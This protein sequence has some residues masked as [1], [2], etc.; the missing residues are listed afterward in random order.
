[1]DLAAGPAATS[2]PVAATPE[3]SSANHHMS[4]HLDEADDRDVLRSSSRHLD[5]GDVISLNAETDLGETE[6]GLEMGKSRNFTLSPE[7]TDYD[8]SELDIN[9]GTELSVSDIPGMNGGAEASGPRQMESFDAVAGSAETAGRR[10]SSSKSQNGLKG[11]FSSMPILED[12]LSSGQ[13]SVGSSASVTSASDTEEDAVT[14]RI[15]LMADRRMKQQPLSGLQQQQQHP[16]HPSVNNGCRNLAGASPLQSSIAGLSGA[17]ST[18]NSASSSSSHQQQQQQPQQQSQMMWAKK[19]SAAISDCDHRNHQDSAM[20][21][22]SFRKFSRLLCVCSVR[23][24][25]FFCFISKSICC[26]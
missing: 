16:L 6:V 1:V 11:Q 10:R 23:S 19:L 21:Q 4:W 18:K 13:S 2:T 5:R 9:N 26:N 15:P 22:G 8:D 20:I 17:R 3:G 14:D 24:T 25:F 7:T 12:G